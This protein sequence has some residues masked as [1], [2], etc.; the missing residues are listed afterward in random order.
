MPYI[1]DKN[2]NDH[3]VAASDSACMSIQYD[4]LVDADFK[5]VNNVDQ[6]I[7]HIKYETGFEYNS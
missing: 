3:Y 2:W 4:I 7:T 6:F 5:V 1:F